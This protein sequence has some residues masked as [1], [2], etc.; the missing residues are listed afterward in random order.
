M[1][2]VRPPVTEQ[3]AISWQ[4]QRGWMR[5][6]GLRSVNTWQQARAGTWASEHRSW[7]QRG[8]YGGYSI[9][10]SRFVLA[11]GSQHGFRMRARPSMYMG[12]PRF[13]Y[14]GY[15]FL[16]V[17]P[18]PEYWA[19]DWYESDDLYIAE[20]DGYYLHNRRDPSIRL[21]ITITL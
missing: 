11:F 4:Q 19:E 21:A 5:Q 3:Q 2:Q 8:G 9:P 1:R 15:A 6:G 14:A 10:P 13:W 18:W 17:D 7:A 12:Y 16:M 20:D